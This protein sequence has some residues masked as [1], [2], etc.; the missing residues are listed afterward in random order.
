M[1]LRIVICWIIFSVVT[2]TAA[3]AEPFA[4]PPKQYSIVK[5]AN[6]SRACRPAFSNNCIRLAK[7]EDVVVLAW[8]IDDKPRRGLYCLR[9]LN[10]SQ[11]YYAD[12]TAIEVNGVPVPT[13]SMDKQPEEKS[14]TAEDCKALPGG[15]EGLKTTTMDQLSR[16]VECLQMDGGAQLSELYKKWVYVS[17]CNQ[18]RQGY[19]MQYVNDIELDRARRGVQGA[20]RE[21]LKRNPTLGERKDQ[22][23][24]DA[25]RRKLT[26]Y[27]ELCKARAAEL[28]NASSDG[29]IVV[30]KP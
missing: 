17:V 12:L 2:A 14:I 25:S 7:G 10:M 20:E 5:V 11:C 16:H 24:Q 1:S 29:A 3:V 23:W 18:A 30:P 19:L 27:P 15:I 13:I 28:W 4:E 8:Q 6:E 22:I 9:P 21:L 26:V